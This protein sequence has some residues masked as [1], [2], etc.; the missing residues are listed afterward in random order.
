M[1][2]ENETLRPV[3]GCTDV[4][5][6]RQEKVLKESN[7]IDL[8]Y[9]K[10]LNFIEE[11]EGYIYIGPAVTHGEAAD[12]ALLQEKAPVLPSACITVGSPQIR[13]RGT[14][15]GNICHA[16]P[17]GDSIPALYVLNAEVKLENTGGE[18]WV[19]I[20]GFFTGPGK[21]LRNNDELVTALRFKPLEKT[22][23][24]RF[25]KLGQRKSL[26]CSKVSLAF[27][28][29]VKDGRLTDVRIA[30]G[31]VAPTVIRAPITEGFLE[32]NE[33]T[34]EVVRKACEL[35]STEAKPI[36]DVRS[37]EKYRKNMV[38]VLLEKS[39]LNKL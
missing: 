18:R 15:G 32:G 34:E 20:A 35:I 29:D 31:A 21:T 26:S 16:S 28:A 27:C 12:S 2:E 5:V 24:S 25:I 1:A 10:E 13:N 8:S 38:S 19:P 23:L 33:I 11:K 39:L 37:T 36:S 30:M 4:A 17:S 7:Y 3:A 6:G 22:Y 9:I 14:I